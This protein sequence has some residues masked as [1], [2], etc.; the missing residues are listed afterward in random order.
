M[1]V[2]LPG[3]IIFAPGCCSTATLP[4]ADAQMT[5]PRPVRGAARGPESVVR[6]TGEDSIPPSLAALSYVKE[7]RSPPTQLRS[8]ESRERRMV[9]QD[10]A[11]WN[12]LMRWRQI[13]E[14]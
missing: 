1:L 4:V 3:S 10:I 9:E 11:S 14:L 5:A 13:E 6:Q 7:N 12:P 8:C 2:S